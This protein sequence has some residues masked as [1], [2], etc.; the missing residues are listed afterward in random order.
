MNDVTAAVILLLLSKMCSV[1][2]LSYY[3]SYCCLMSV[4]Q[5]AA[6]RFFSFDQSLNLHW[7]HWRCFDGSEGLSC[8]SRFGRGAGCDWRK[9]ALKVC[10]SKSLSQ[11]SVV[12]LVARRT[13]WKTHS[14]FI[15]LRSLAMDTNLLSNSGYLVEHYAVEH[16]GKILIAWL[17]L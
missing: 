15:E 6:K 2:C 16:L 3:S 12:Q 10:L 4:T 9:V 13:N 1:Y 11:V 8:Y 7:G 14:K 17:T 5:R